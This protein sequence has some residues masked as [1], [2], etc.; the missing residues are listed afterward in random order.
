MFKNNED[1]WTP[2]VTIGGH[3]GSVED[4]AWDPAGKYLISVGSDQTSRIH[5]QWLRSNEQIMDLSSFVSLF[6][7]FVRSSI[8]LIIKKLIKLCNYN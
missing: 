8:F 6:K 5:A 1:N 7:I 2:G 4:I 3:F